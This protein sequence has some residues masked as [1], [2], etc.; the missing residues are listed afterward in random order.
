MTITVPTLIAAAALTTAALSASAAGAP[1]RHNGTWS[2]ELVTESGLCNARYSYSVAIRDG[3][4]RP[5]SASSGTR[6]S[7]RVSPDGVVGITVAGSGGA[8]TGTG[9]L[10]GTQGSGTWNV[11]SLCT[12]RWTA[13]RGADTR[14]AQVD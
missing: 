13:R 6:V 1:D 4:V 7:G 14:T 11:S 10:S 8:G 5:V 3:E 2:V 9:R 12:G